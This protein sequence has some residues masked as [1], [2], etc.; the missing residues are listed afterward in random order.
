[1]RSRANPLEQPTRIGARLV[2]TAPPKN[3]ELLIGLVCGRGDASSGYNKSKSTKLG[4]WRQ[5][6]V[7][8]VRSTLSA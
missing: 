1:M 2:L 4:R 3:L 7:T 5:T 8:F 6:V